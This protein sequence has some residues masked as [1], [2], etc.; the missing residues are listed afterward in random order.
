MNPFLETAIE[1]EK[2]LLEENI[3]Q[4]YPINHDYYSFLQSL[5]E[6]SNDVQLGEFKYQE[7]IEVKKEEKIPSKNI[8]VLGPKKTIF[9]KK[10]RQPKIAALPAEALDC[11]KIFPCNQSKGPLKDSTE[12]YEYA[13]KQE[14]NTSGKPTPR[15]LQLKAMPE[16]RKYLD[17]FTIKPSKSTDDLPAEKK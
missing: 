1:L 14:D 15:C 10:L 6:D 8:Y 7:E 5:A 2:F 11:V 4:D 17:T 13:W 16:G 9:K 12:G 3:R